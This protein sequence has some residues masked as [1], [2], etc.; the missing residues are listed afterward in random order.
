M[1]GN[2]TSGD[3]PNKKTKAIHGAYN[4]T[5]AVII[6]PKIKL[7]TPANTNFQPWMPIAVP[8]P[9]IQF[10][11]LANMNIAVINK[12]T[13]MVN[14][15]LCSESFATMPAP[16]IAPPMAVKNITTNVS[17]STSTI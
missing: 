13:P 9:W 11:L 6:A 15:I 5:P 8:S 2:A 4:P 16:H 12:A 1:I 7:T 3:I 10:I 14:R 17:G